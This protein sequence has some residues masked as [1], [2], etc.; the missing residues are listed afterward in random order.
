MQTDKTNHHFQRRDKWIGIYIVNQMCYYI[1]D[2]IVINESIEKKSYYVVP[3]GRVHNLFS[4]ER[5]VAATGS[6]FSWLCVY[7]M[8]AWSERVKQSCQ[9]RQ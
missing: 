2:P 7:F 9:K 8:Y 4:K 3:R 1:L 6:L 5:W